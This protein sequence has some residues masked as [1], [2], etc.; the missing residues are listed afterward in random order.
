LELIHVELI[1][2]CGPY[3]NQVHFNN[4]I[5]NWNTWRQFLCNTQIIGPSFSF[6]VFRMRAICPFHRSGRKRHWQV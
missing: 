1:H 2:S 4:C 6:R 3:F 5:R